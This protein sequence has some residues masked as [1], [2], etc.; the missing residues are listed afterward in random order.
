[1]AFNNS[2]L[3]HHAA[4]LNTE[5]VKRTDKEHDSFIDEF[6]TAMRTYQM[7][8]DVENEQANMIFLI[9]KKMDVLSQ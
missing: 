1:M 8:F 2:F 6:F 7:E 3:M 9:F 4:F 5:A